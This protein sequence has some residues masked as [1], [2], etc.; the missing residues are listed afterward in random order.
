MAEFISGNEINLALEKMIKNAEE[1]LILISPY[2]KLHD[3]LK[4]ELKA[5]VANDKLK[6]IVLFGKNEGE[7]EK[8]IKREDIE[9]FI[10]FHNIKICYEKNLH[11]KYYA[12]EEFAILTSMNLHQFSQN[13][14]IE[15]GIKMYPKNNLESLANVLV[16]TQNIDQDANDFFF[17]LVQRSDI[18]YASEPQ[19][20]KELFGLSKKY[21]GSKI[22]I[23]NVDDFFKKKSFYNRDDFPESRPSFNNK[24]S[25]NESNYNN[26]QQYKKSYNQN[27]AFCI[28]TGKSIPY[29]INLPF[30]TEAFETW[31]QF[32]NVD[33]PESFCHSTGQPSYGKTSMRNPILKNDFKTPQVW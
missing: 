25:T 33:Y 31:Q 26:Q 22:T 18:V 16:S 14:N 6:I 12:S 27:T 19:Y 21:T 30:C 7:A 1:Y 11:A 8:S 2:I 13:T 3:R 10:Q 24:T 17:N 20:K 32:G 5:K 15:A 9:F 4:A 29:N 23:N 28:R